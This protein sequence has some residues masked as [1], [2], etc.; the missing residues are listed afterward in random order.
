M[1]YLTLVLSLGAL[2]PPLPA[3]DTLLVTRDSVYS[4]LPA[5]IVTATQARE[6]E[7]PVTFSTLTQAQLSERYSVQDIPVLL[8]DLPSMTFYSENGNGIGYNY[9][10]LRG[11]DQ[12][13]LS[14]MI[15]GVPQN[16][17]EDHNVYWIDFPD[18]LGSTG[19]VQVQRGAGSA[20]YGPPAIGGSINL[21]TDPFNRKPGITVESELGFQE[22]SDSTT[23]LPI[24]TRKYAV[25]VN[26]G[27]V[28][29]Q[30]MVYGRLGRIQSDGYRTNSWVNLDSYFLGAIRI[31]R[32]MTT[33]L[34]FYGGPLT[35]G[36]AY[37]GLPKFVNDNPRLRRQNLADWGLD[38]TGSGYSY[39]TQRRPQ[40]SESFS[41][42]HYELIHDWRLSPGTTLH[43]TL[44]YYTGDGYFDYD[45]SWADTSLLRIGS[46]YGFPTAQNPAN[47]LVRAFVGNKQW[48]WLP[49]I[50]IDHT[51]GTLTLGAEVRIHRSTHWGKIQYAEGLPPNFDPDYHF[52]EYNG[53]K[54]ILSVFGHELYRPQENL[55][56]MF[57][58]Q[59]VRNR[60]G[61]SNE[62]YLG[63]NFSL[64]YFFANPRVGANY[65]LN[66]EW[67]GYL[68]LAYTSREP[69]L[70]NLYAVEDSY[71]GATP[72]FEADT[73]GGTVRYDFTK[74]LA[75]PERLLDIE[76][77]AVYR[78]A[79][80][81]FSADVFWMEFSD[82]LVKSG[83][84]DIF[85]QPVTGNAD[86]T[87]H[88]GVELDGRLSAGPMFSIS[89]NL[90]L[91]HNRLIRYSVIDDAGIIQQGARVDLDG[92]S[93]AG[94]PDV[95]GNLRATF[96]S[97]DGEV[98]FSAKYVGP[99]YTDNFKIEDHRNDAYTLIDAEALD[100]IATIGGVELSLRFEIH[101]V[102]NRFFS[103]SGE[104][105]AFFPAAERSYLWGM[106]VDL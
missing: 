21:V 69:V 25:S 37:T 102:F 100:R 97:D 84:V 36:L 46:L 33:R 104:G 12:R 51:S 26:S 2:A 49:N 41:Q 88:I 17:P 96:R 101:N 38:S 60:Y 78:G 22:F 35:D 98:S 1:K 34:E 39:A 32:E 55:T 95:L 13:R 77:G 67:N 53:E 24:A 9:V 76:A 93:I 48:G 81:E 64:P 90:T 42:P 52:Y 54:D 94:F 44:F 40:E 83:Q 89:G 99:F 68:S 45:A 80:A 20:F 62:K 8:S 91:S 11:F 31:D 3:Q 79:N 6:R 58:L 30:Y 43:N 23:S 56:L 4:Y 82:E 71:F 92:N 50:G 86:R 57:D 103:L 16:D 105:N 66:P 61:I 28:G 75:K 106:K 19:S 65:N 29:K 14:V 70:R 7:T 87:R 15:N 72:Q 74:P 27:L 10:N 85:G 47:A 63:E 59:L 5:V 73:S 18:L